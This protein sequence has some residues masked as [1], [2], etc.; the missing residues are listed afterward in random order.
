MLMPQGTSEVRKQG[1]FIAND[2][3]IKLQLKEQCAKVLL[4]MKMDELRMEPI[5]PEMMEQWEN[6]AKHKITVNIP[7]GAIEKSTEWFPYRA[8]MF[9]KVHPTYSGEGI[10]SLQD[11]QLLEAKYTTH[12]VE[13]IYE[14]RLN[15]NEQEEPQTY[16]G[17]FR[18]SRKDGHAMAVALENSLA[19]DFV[20][21]K[22]PFMSQIYPTEDQRK[23]SRIHEKGFFEI[24]GGPG[25]QKGIYT[26]QVAPRPDTEV[27]KMLYIAPALLCLFALILCASIAW[28][29]CP[30]R[31][32][33]RK[34]TKK[35][36]PTK[37]LRTPMAPKVPHTWP[38][39]GRKV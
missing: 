17:S 12:P 37:L 2:R 14:V 13:W 10:Y 31:R 7:I 28:K 33:I 23:A 24:R 19:D 36:D 1:T 11:D 6:D 3:R 34:R 22:L 20:D 35:F 26:F 5:A 38:N 27:S 32:C 21:M 8:T 15:T 30:I 9:P 16:K 4:Q 39:H 18:A 25:P 29:V